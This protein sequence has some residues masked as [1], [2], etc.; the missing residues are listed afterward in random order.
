LHVLGGKVGGD[1]FVHPF[2]GAK[3]YEMSEWMKGPPKTN[4]TKEKTKKNKPNPRPPNPKKKH[5]PTP[6][7]K[8]PPPPPPP[9]KKHPK[10][11]LPIKKTKAPNN[12]PSLFLTT[13]SISLFW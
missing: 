2:P 13:K 7:Q 6:Q 11:D 4:A 12:R 3:K 9:T 10:K 5:T 8:P 1:T